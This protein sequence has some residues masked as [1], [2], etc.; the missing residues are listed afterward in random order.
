MKMNKEFFVAGKDD[1][2]TKKKCGGKKCEKPECNEPAQTTVH[3]YHDRHLRVKCLE[4]ALETSCIED[5]ALK[6]ARRY[7]EWVQN[8]G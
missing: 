6:W 2:P 4:L 3:P 5:D 1:K 8:G 7:W